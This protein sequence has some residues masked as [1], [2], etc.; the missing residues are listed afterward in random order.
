[1]S[2]YRPK[3]SRF[4]HYDFVMTGTRYTGSTNLVAKSEARAFEDRVRRRIASGEEARPRI[5]LSEACG[6]WSDG[7]GRHEANWPT[8]KGQVRTLIR[9]LG[10]ARPL[11]D[12]DAGDFRKFV[13]RRRAHVTARGGPLANASIN[14]ELE[15]AGRIWRYAAEPHEQ[16]PSGFAAST[17]G[18]RPLKLKEPR[19]RVRELGVDEEARLWKHAPN[20][21]IAAVVEFA[22]LSG[23]RRTSVT[24][25]L[26][27]KVDLG[28]ARASVRVKGGGWHSFPLTPRLVAIVAGRPKV[29]AQVFT[30]V[31]ERPAPPRADRPRRLRGDRYPF[32]KQGWT[33]RWR[34]WLAAAGIEDFRFHDLRHT[35][36]TRLLR[37]TGNL[38]T[39][40]KLLGHADIATTARYAHALEDDVRQ[41]M[42]AAESR[43]SPE[44]TPA[45]P[46]KNGTNCKERS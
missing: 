23:Q 38:K 20:A 11:S 29:C 9:I 14:R 46:I 17:I 27:S 26:W 41:G 16:A 39:V 3:R 33:R 7:K 2:V 4:Y 22:L 30:Y 36:G 8:S 19:E 31:C 10:G 42:L 6:L 13:A 18:W 1:M 15:L 5:T 45:A 28:A 34:D 24:T 43:T 21:D 35:R 37:A 25:L 12:I 40:Q 32:S 44:P